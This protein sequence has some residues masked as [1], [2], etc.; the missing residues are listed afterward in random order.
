MSK[1]D[2]SGSG[3]LLA[4]LLVTLALH[5]PF[6]NQAFHMDDGRDIE[7]ARNALQKPLFPNDMLYVFD[8]VVVS[9]AGHSHPPLNAYFLALV[10]KLTGRLTERLAHGF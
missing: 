8:G 6:L 4:L 2:R 3:Q 7:L 9:M 5:L 10:W 1:S